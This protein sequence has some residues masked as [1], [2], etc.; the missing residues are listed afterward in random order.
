MLLSDIPACE[1]R[2]YLVEVA[3]EAERHRRQS[4]GIVDTVN[5]PKNSL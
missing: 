2:D 5:A 1:Y 4:L 3:A